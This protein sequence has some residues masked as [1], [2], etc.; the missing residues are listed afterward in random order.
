MSASKL[1]L[2]AVESV[3]AVIQ[4]FSPIDA[5]PVEPSVNDP[6]PNSKVYSD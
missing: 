2:L 4:P 3:Q 1:A 5:K 6:S